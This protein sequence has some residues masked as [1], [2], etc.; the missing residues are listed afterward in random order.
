MTGRF[1]V[2]RGTPWRCSD[3]Y[4]GGHTPLH[5]LDTKIG[6]VYKGYPLPDEAFLGF[7]NWV[8]AQ[9]EEK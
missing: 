8:V 4:C 7:I 6:Q 1:E 9:L 2:I 5:I 3:H